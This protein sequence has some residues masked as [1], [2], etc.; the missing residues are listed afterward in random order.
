MQPL[1][2]FSILLPE[3]IKLFNMK[4]IIILLALMIPVIV[5]AQNEETRSLKSFS[6]VSVS[7]SI[8]LILTKG[9]ENVAEVSTEG[10]L[11][12]VIT[13]ISGNKLSVKKASSNG[14]SSNNDK[15]VVRVTYTDELN[16]LKAS[17]SSNMLVEGTLKTSDLSVKAS[18]SAN[19]KFSATAD[20][21]T[22]T[23]SSSADIEATIQ[24]RNANMKVSSS[25]TID[26]TGNTNALE[27]SASSSGRLR[28]NDF[29]CNIGD[30]SA[31]SSGS[32]SVAVKDE[33]SA[34]ASSSGK[35]MYEGRPKL[36]DLN[37]SSGGKVR[38]AD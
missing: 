27:A 3:T 15:V 33:L 1:N 29:S 4:K 32:I 36:K 24:A 7:Q 13:E 26:I 25:G 37:A 23:A 8:K 9:N 19:I 30:L 6:E 17:S 11:E 12:D 2:F 34:S 31:S 18:S 5:L 10:D 20:A 28:G 16:E 14:W 38:S 22:I 35:V 21:V